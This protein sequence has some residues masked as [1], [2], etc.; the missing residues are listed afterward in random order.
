MFLKLEP[1]AAAAFYMLTTEE[2][3]MTYTE[4]INHGSGQ[5][6]SPDSPVGAVCGGAWGMW[7]ASRRTDAGQ[8]DSFPERNNMNE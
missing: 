8:G 5:P 2:G 6:G 3:V 1:R 4:V 7:P